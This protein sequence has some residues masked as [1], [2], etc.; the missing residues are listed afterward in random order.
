MCLRLLLLLV[1]AIWQQGVN[2]I[3]ELLNW[4][5][6]QKWLLDLP[7]SYPTVVNAEQIENLMVGVDERIVSMGE[8]II[9]ASFSSLFGFAAFLISLVLVP[10]MVF[11][12]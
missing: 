8:S 2:L 10:L 3:T 1:P 4:D 12:C 11:S 7:E 6:T 5:K 9:S